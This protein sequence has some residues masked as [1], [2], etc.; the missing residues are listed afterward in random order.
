MDSLLK[1]FDREPTAGNVLLLNELATL[2][3]SS[4]VDSALSLSTYALKMAEQ[5]QDAEGKARALNG[6]GLAIYLKSDFPNALGYFSEA[7]ALYDSLGDDRGKANALSSLANIYQYFGDLTRAEKIYKETLEIRNRINDKKGV[8]TNYVNLGRLYI[9]KGK[10]SQ[11]AEAFHDALTAYEALE[12]KGGIAYT[13]NNIGVFY[14][15]L[16]QYEKAKDFLEN[17]KYN[18][19]QNQD[20]KGIALTN[21]NLANMYFQQGNISKALE[22]YTNSSDLYEHLE[23]KY[24][25]SISLL[26]IGQV[27]EQLHNY[28]LALEHY[29]KA[30]TLQKE[31]QNKLG[32]A[33][34]LH[35]I[36][37]IYLLSGNSSKA[38]SYFTSSIELAKEEKFNEVLKDNYET[39]Y[40][41]FK[42]KAY[43]Y[44]AITYFERFKEIND[45]LISEK[46][47]DTF[48]KMQK[49]Y[50]IEQ[51]ESEISNLREREALKTLELAESSYRQKMLLFLAIAVSLIA[52]VIYIAYRYKQKAAYL[53]REQTVTLE[54]VNSELEERVAERTKEL[55]EK[56][57][58]LENE[59]ERRKKTEDEL[60]LAKEKAETSDKLKTEF[61]AQI[62]H[63]IRTPVNGI[64]NL[65]TII[66]DEYEK[67]VN[68]ELLFLLQSIQNDGDR[69]VRTMDLLKD[70]ALLEAGCFEILPQKFDIHKDVLLEEFSNFTQYANEKSIE[71]QLHTSGEQFIIETDQYSVRQIIVNIIDNAI[72][73]TDSGTVD[74]LLIEDHQGVIFEVRDTGVGISEEYQASIY[75]IFS[76]EDQ[77]FSRAYEGNGIGLA[78]VKRLCDI[79]NFT[80]DFES[81]KEIG[82]NFRVLFKSTNGG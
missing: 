57:I 82:T 39:L 40:Q 36:G 25:I 41:Y 56:N 51:K 10:Y 73:F 66:C 1:T 20:I 6:V 53:L 55:S 49:L 42:S 76:Q 75:K 33:K 81:R 69:L 62:S 23:N 26:K 9:K 27:Y 7:A 70:M 31:G 11:A 52:L 64:M 74:V 65:S 79:N 13:L 48:A 43:Y 8:A 16:E 45:I 35:R 30:L 14:T 32:Q 58:S 4:D 24:G 78:L 15:D 50:E 17:A 38:T 12:D 28:Q 22:Y 34:T 77:G 61:L 80:I 54:K 29:Q 72:K 71:Y 44:K 18:Y 60:V 37:Q 63:E 67:E 19:E 5:I 68:E 21:E 3:R 47:E 2:I 59:I 46:A